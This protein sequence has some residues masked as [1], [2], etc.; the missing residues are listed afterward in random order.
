MS[1]GSSRVGWLGCT[2]ASLGALATVPLFGHLQFQGSH[3]SLD[4]SH[5]KSVGTV[6]FSSKPSVLCD[7]R[8]YWSDCP[9]F[10]VP[11]LGTLGRLE[12]PGP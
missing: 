5:R 1:A 12:F 8:P 3:V 6:P 11:T 4:V 10:L 9:T 7:L 2:V